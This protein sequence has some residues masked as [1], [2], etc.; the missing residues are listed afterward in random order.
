[1]TTS[2]D[3]SP[4]RWTQVNGT[5]RKCR[6]RAQRRNAEVLLNQTVRNV[7]P[8]RTTGQLLAVGLEE[9]ADTTDGHFQIIDARQGNHA[10]VIRPRPVEGRTLHH[11]QLLGE[12]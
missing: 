11:Q 9:V 12:Q 8:L 10:E 4:L 2:R 1:M 7:W 3:P 5:N 6:R